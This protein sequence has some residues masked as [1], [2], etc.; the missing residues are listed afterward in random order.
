MVALRST[1]Q[2]TYGLKVAEKR[3]CRRLAK[4]GGYGKNG[5]SCDGCAQGSV[6]ITRT[7]TAIL[8]PHV[9]TS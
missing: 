1:S 4:E 9:F 5:S 7:E 6:L 3:H 8:D 2:W